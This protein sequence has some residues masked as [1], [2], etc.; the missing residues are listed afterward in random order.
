MRAS[1]ER[2]NLQNKIKRWEEQMSGRGR[3]SKTAAA[4]TR[5]SLKTKGTS[6]PLSSVPTGGCLIQLVEEDSLTLAKMKHIAEGRLQDYKSRL[7]GAKKPVEDQVRELHRAEGDVLVVHTDVDR[8]KLEKDTLPIPTTVESRIDAIVDACTNAI[9]DAIVVDAYTNDIVD[10]LEVDASTDAAADGN[11]NDGGIESIVR[12]VID[13][14]LDAIE[15]MDAIADATVVDACTND[16]VDAMEVDASTNVAADGN[17]NDGG[18]KSIVRAA[19]DALLDA[20]EAMGK[21]AMV[22]DTRGMGEEVLIER[23]AG[24]CEAVGASDVTTQAEVVCP[25]DATVEDTRGRGEEVLIEREAGTREAVGASDMSPF[26]DL[27]GQ[28]CLIPLR[29]ADPSLPVQLPN[30]HLR[31]WINKLRLI[32]ENL[33][34]ARDRQESYTNL[35]RSLRS[36]NPGD[37]VFLRVKPKRSS[38]RVGKYKKLAYRYCGPFEILRR[39]GEQS[40]ELSLPPRLHVHN[41]FHVSLLKEHVYDPL[42]LLNDEDTVLVNQE[43]FQMMPEQLLEVKERKLRHR[44]IREVLVQ[45]KGYP[46]KDASWEDWDRLVAQFPYLAN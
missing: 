11:V 42:H 1:E 19:I 37:K 35:K 29:F 9:V 18:T 16:I 24:T 27:Y 13:A 5:S 20:V 7:E 10:A 32:R 14:I 31:R 12:A 25:S 26:K 45:W 33:K 34:R 40:Y 38:L 28:D 39:I 44:T 4:S 30:T 41:V 43:E 6:V 22:E 17:V 3:G 8:A 23:E 15:A 46:A 2:H 36:F 21:D